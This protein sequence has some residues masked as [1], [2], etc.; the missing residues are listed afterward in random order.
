MHLLVHVYAC[1]FAGEY[2]NASGFVTKTY[3]EPTCPSVPAGEQGQWV[4]PYSCHLTGC[5]SNICKGREE[6]YKVTKGE[7]DTGE[8]DA[9]EGRN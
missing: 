5:I 1:R 9:L 8:R 4:G 6:T 2:A 7:G 3:P